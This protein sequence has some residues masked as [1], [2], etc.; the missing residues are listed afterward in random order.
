MTRWVT[1]AIL[2]GFLLIVGVVIV[3]GFVRAQAGEDCGQYL[4]LAIERTKKAHEGPPNLTS[5][6]YATEGLSWG[7]IARACQGE[8][9]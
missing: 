6:V 1:P 5:L 4:A 3:L 2:I 8:R 7:N 9:R